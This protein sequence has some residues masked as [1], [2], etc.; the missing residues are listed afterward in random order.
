MQRTYVSTLRKREARETASPKAGKGRE[1]KKKRQTAQSVYTEELDEMRR[2][3]DSEAVVRG[4]R[5]RMANAAL[6]W[7][8]AA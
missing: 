6:H 3:L 2:D 4:R 5:E 8:G 7:C 1:K